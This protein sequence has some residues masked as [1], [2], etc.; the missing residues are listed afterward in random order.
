MSDSEDE[1][2]LSDAGACFI[3]VVMSLTMI[4]C[5]KVEANVKIDQHVD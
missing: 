4:F 2:S 1:L 3:T 5:V